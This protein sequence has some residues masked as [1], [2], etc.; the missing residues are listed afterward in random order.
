MTLPSSEISYLDKNINLPE[1]VFQRFQQTKDFVNHSV[2]SLTDSAQQTGESLKE[3]ATHATSRAV[4]TVTTTLGQ[5]KASLEQTLY[6]AEQVKSTTSEAV[7]TAISS[8]MSDW[9]EQYPTLLRLVQILGWAVNHPIISLVIL[10]FALAVVWSLIKAI[11]RLI[12]SA[13]LS[14]LRVPFKLL[15]AFVKVSF[16]WFSRVA[17][18]TTKQLTNSSTTDN[19]PTL[20]PAISQQIHKDKQQRLIE[21]STRLEEIQKEQNQ[22][23]QEA[24][25]ILAPE[26]IAM[27]V[28]FKHYVE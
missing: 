22:L 11:G 15:Q 3:T 8:S 21:I 14:L 25:E 6:S 1:K 18:L 20:L 23:L 7:Q 2:N 19:M 17:S 24:A 13:S 16:S 4:D 12:E 5:A 27:E 26:K 9:F 10:L 28:K